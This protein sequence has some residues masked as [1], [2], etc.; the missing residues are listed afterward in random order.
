MRLWSQARQMGAY[1]A[2][3]MVARHSGEDVHMD[4]CFEIFAHVTKFFNYKVFDLYFE[5]AFLTVIV[6]AKCNQTW[7]M[8]IIIVIIP[9]FY[10]TPLPT[11]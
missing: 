7:T 3:C 9:K 10:Y 6:R 1:A 4:F 11:K 8:S 2:K 5:P